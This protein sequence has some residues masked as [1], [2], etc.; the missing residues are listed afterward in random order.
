MVTHGYV[1]FKYRGIYYNFYNHSDSYYSCLGENV[2]NEVYDMISN[3]YMEYYKKELLR[4][5]LVEQ[6]GE[7]DGHFH[8][9]HSAI[10]FYDCR[11]YYTSYDEPG[12][13]YV[14]IIDFDEEEMIIEKY[15]QN[16]YTFNLF[17]IPENWMEIVKNSDYYMYENSEEIKAEMNTDRIKARIVELEAELTQLHTLLEKV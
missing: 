15:G 8:S 12:S 1:S 5:P 9:I 4:I 13:E 10:C 17:D 11:Q 6:T 7:G 16:R 3:N 2:V 14:Y